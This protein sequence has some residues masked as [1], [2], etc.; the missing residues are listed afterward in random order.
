MC[1]IPLF[2]KIREVMVGAGMDPMML[3]PN[4]DTDADAH[5]T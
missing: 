2:G 4:T 1:F 5:L 3:T